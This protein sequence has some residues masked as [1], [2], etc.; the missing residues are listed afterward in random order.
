MGE[1]YQISSQSVFCIFHNLGA[2]SFTRFSSCQSKRPQPKKTSMFFFFLNKNPNN[3]SWFYM[4]A[5]AD[6][7]NGVAE[8]KRTTARKGGENTKK[9]AVKEDTIRLFTAST[10]SIHIQYPYHP[11]HPNTF[12]QFIRLRGFIFFLL[13]I[14][15]NARWYKEIWW[16][17]TYSWEFLG[18][19]WIYSLFLLTPRRCSFLM[20][21]IIVYVFL[22]FGLL[23]ASD[24]SAR[25]YSH[26]G[27]FGTEMEK[28]KTN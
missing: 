20:S 11:Y 5:A 28:N 16:F 23:V 15:L 18:K 27:T 14:L 13:W 3:K 26:F 6:H 9:N 19:M 2:F 10:V 17:R 24:S 7:L 8:H 12:D 25:T 21:Y 22:V 1:E 4:V